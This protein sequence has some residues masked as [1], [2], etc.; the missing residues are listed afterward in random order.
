MSGFVVT[1]PKNSPADLEILVVRGETRKRI[2]LVK[3]GDSFQVEHK[4]VSMRWSPRP[5]RLEQTA[6]GQIRPDTRKQP[7]RLARV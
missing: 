3:P 6:D 1:N 2:G 7:P 4:E 5:P